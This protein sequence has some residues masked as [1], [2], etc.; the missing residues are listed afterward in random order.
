L[1]YNSRKFYLKNIIQDSKLIQ[2]AL[3]NN[4]TYQNNTLLNCEFDNKIWR[5]YWPDF[6][7]FYLGLLNKFPIILEKCKKTYN[8]GLS[9]DLFENTETSDFDAIDKYAS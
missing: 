5:T 9:K 8:E 3:K 4:F 7:Y 6:D 1:N 2:T